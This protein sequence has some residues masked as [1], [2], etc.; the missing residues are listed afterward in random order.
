MITYINY[1]NNKY[2][3]GI[4]THLGFLAGNVKKTTVKIWKGELLWSSKP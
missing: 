4:S 1:K 2:P 3:C